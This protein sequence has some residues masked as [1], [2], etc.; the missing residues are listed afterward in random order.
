MV[1]RGRLAFRVFVFIPEKTAR[2]FGKKTSWVQMVLDSGFL[3]KHFL[4]QEGNGHTCRVD[5][6]GTIQFLAKTIFFNLTT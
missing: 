6:R 3:K 1:M 2:N 4:S 5:S